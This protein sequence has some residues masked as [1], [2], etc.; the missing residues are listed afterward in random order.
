PTARLAPLVTG[1]RA[2]R[3]PTA[4]WAVATPIG[5]RSSN[6]RVAL[7][8]SGGPPS[9][10][11]PATGLCRW[12]HDDARVVSQRA[13]RLLDIRTGRLE[14]DVYAQTHSS[15]GFVFNGL[16]LLLEGLSTGRRCELRSLLDPA[17]VA[18]GANS[19][20]R[21]KSAATR[22]ASAS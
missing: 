22:S 10:Y 7:A 1:S 9:P 14:N 20:T 5:C 6:G 12:G 18:A 4:A 19:V 3:S 8:F 13:R 21:W 11:R 17:A 2:P 15:A 16:L